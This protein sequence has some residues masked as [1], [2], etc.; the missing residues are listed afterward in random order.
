MNKWLFLLLLPSLAFAERTA[1]LNMRKDP[2]YVDVQ[3]NQL[4]I[5]P[6]QRIVAAP[7][8]CIPKNDFECLLE[9]MERV[10]AVRYALLLLRPGSASLQREVCGMLQKHGIDRGIE[11]WEDGRNI[12]PEQ[13]NH[14]FIPLV[15][16][17]GLEISTPLETRLLY[18]WRAHRGNCEVMVHSN[19]VVFLTN[20]VVLSL[21]ELQTPENLF[22]RM[23]DQW[24]AGEIFPRIFC[25]ESGSDELYALIMDKIYERGAKMNEWTI[26]GTPIEVPA[27]GRSPVYLECRGNRL[28][29]ISAVAP[30]REFEISNLNSFDPAAQFVCLLVRPDSFDIFRSARKTAWEHGLDVSCE[31]QDESG[32]LAIG[33]EGNPLFP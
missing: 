28:F 33:P 19:S 23:L 21:K 14:Y 10:R 9:D 31:L 25:K 12:L 2:V 5:Y 6:E 24:E 22:D 7:E 15:P 20:N 17:C 29:S 3:S 30:A 8:L 18:E 4:T 26:A 1:S 16:S 27:N 32:P 13:M 11:P